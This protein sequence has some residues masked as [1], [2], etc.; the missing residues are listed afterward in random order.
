MEII[1]R[2]EIYG[3]ENEKNTEDLLADID[4]DTVDWQNNFDDSLKEPS[5]LPSRA[6]QTF[7]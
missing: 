6:F 7:Y 4:K 3:S 2:N 5:V 1:P